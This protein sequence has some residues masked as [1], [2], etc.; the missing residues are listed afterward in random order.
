MRKILKS[1]RG[2]TLVESAIA[3]AMLSVLAYGVFSLS[4]NMKAM[5]TQLNSV[6]A[7][8]QFKQEILQSLSSNGGW[9]KSL[10]ESG[11]ACLVNK[12]DCASLAGTPMPLKVYRADGRLV[13]DSSQPTMGFDRDGNACNSF[14][15]ATGNKSCP[16][17]YEVTVSAVCPL[18]EACTNPQEVITGTLLYSGGA[19]AVN[20]IGSINPERHKFSNFRGEHTNTLTGAC[21]AFGGVF[22]EATNSCRLP[23][24]GDCPAGQVV[25]RI[26]PATNTKDCRV[27]IADIECP[28]GSVLKAIGADGSPKCFPSI[29]PPRTCQMTNSCPITPECPEP[30]GC[31][32][33]ETGSPACT[34]CTGP[35]CNPCT[36]P[37]CVTDGGSDGGSDGSCDGGDSDGGSGDGDGG[38]DGDGG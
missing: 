20:E 33:C 17:R 18:S 10:D 2:F 30:G 25:V 3:V 34:V 37:G 29:C 35:G 14:S 19:N 27:L 21:A 6:K 1:Q 24:A 38:C 31:P 36:G 12:T 28:V 8:N 16:F 4:S 5:A 26:D 15:V 9:E 23:M 11:V 22:D 32:T 13:A 7:I